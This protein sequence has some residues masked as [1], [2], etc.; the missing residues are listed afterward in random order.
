MK[1]KC[2]QTNRKKRARKDKAENILYPKKCWSKKNFI[3]KKVVS[4]KS[5]VQENRSCAKLKMSPG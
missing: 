2:G 1:E 5:S 4:K 3:Y